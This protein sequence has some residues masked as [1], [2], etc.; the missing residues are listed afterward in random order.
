M[1]GEYKTIFEIFL[2]FQGLK[3]CTSIIFPIDCIM[4]SVLSSSQPNTDRIDICCFSTKYTALRSK[5]K[6][7]LLTRSQ[8]NLSKWSD[9][10]IREVLNC[11]VELALYKVNS[12]CYS[13][14]TW[15]S[16]SSSSSTSST[17]NCSF[18]SSW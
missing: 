4:V 8:V 9:M 13:S 10:S 7:W 11:F 3:I 15:A 17:C 12:E 1:N 16:S 6:Y 2:A 14:T 5:R 18:F